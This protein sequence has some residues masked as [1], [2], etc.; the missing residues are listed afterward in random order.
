MR[1]A[2]IPSLKQHDLPSPLSPTLP[3]DKPSDKPASP[4]SPPPAPAK[5]ASPPPSEPAP[6]P[7]KAPE[8][9]SDPSESKDSDIVDMDTFRQLLELDDDATHDF[10]KGMAWAYFTQAEQTFKDMEKALAGQNLAQ[11]SSLGHYLKGSSAA[12]GLSKVQAS[13]EKIQH[14]GQRRDEAAGEDVTESVA[15]EK[16][17]GLLSQV[18]D[19]YAAAESWLKRWYKE[20]AVDEAEPQPDLS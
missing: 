17:K 20:N 14:F 13:C 11:L 5:S 19:E 4:P 16:I 12:L 18:N 8:P 6:N 3:V 2:A 15:L 7:E 10:S 9:E 1:E